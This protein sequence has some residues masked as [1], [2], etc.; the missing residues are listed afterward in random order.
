M[1]EKKI[2]SVDVD[3]LKDRVSSKARSVL[4]SAKDR[5]QEVGQK[6][7]DKAIEVKDQAVLGTLDKGIAMLQKAKKSLK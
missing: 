7:N 6:L 3:L 5:V 2:V 1:A 4:E